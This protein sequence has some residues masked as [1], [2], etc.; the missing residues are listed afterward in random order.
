MWHEYHGVGLGLLVTNVRA[1][2]TILKHSIRV[3]CMYTTL[4]TDGQG[5]AACSASLLNST[6]II[7]CSCFLHWKM[8]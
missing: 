1:E 4:T 5:Y 6:I 3:K 2:N 7:A 8:A